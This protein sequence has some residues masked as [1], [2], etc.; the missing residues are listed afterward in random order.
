LNQ[1]KLFP[2]PNTDISTVTGDLWSATA[3]KTGVIVEFYRASDNSDFIVPTT[4]RPQLLKLFTAFKTFGIE[5]PS[6]NIRLS[7]YFNQ[8]W[9]N[10]KAE[11]FNLLN[12]LY[13]QP[14]RL[15]INDFS[16]F[17]WFPGS[18]VLPIDRFGISVDDG[19]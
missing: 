1:I 12:T 17:N 18:P 4:L 3:I 14:R 13:N 8:R 11:L 7:Q 5:G 9:E 16:T 19:E 2:I 10:K 15:V 6:Q